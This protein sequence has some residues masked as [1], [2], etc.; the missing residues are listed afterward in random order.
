[1]SAGR[2]R[3]PESL[4]ITGTD[5]GQKTI[6]PVDNAD[7]RHSHAFLILRVATTMTA[8]FTRSDLVIA[9]WRAH[10]YEFGLVG[11]ELP[12]TN[13]VN[14]KIDGAVGLI[15]RGYIEQIEV[16]VLR[17]TPSGARHAKHPESAPHGGR[18]TKRCVWCDRR[19][20]TKDE[21]GDPSCRVC[22]SETA[23]SRAN[24]SKPDE[25]STLNMKTSQRIT[26]ETLVT[27]NRLLSPTYISEKIRSS[28]MF[29]GLVLKSLEELG[30]V[31]NIPK[32]DGHEDYGWRITDAGV[33]RVRT[34]A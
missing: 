20:T 6:E 7:V 23:A 4:D 8:T 16:G 17:V 30:L 15:A 29:A 19:A 5:C 31:Q 34:S 25:K 26:L 1:M 12:N 18:R 9:C 22:E 24:E 14:P 10:P 2:D 3:V 11:Y 13:A 32:S 28:A 21:D 33:L 27:A